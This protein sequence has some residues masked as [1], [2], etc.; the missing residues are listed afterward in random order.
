MPGPLRH[1]QL[2]SCPSNLPDRSKGVSGAA[3][4]AV[5]LAAG[6]VH[7]LPGRTEYPAQGCF[8]LV[9]GQAQGLV[10]RMS[11]EVAIAGVTFQGC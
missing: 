4:A 3:P 5:A 11:L 10:P 9:E 2:R 8:A 1:D 6:H 7:P